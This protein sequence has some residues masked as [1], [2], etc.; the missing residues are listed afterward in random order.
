MVFGEVDDVLILG[1]D[2]NGEPRYCFFVK[3]I[4][5]EGVQPDPKKL[6]MLPKMPQMMQ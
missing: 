5:R 6:C 1:H 3:V 4:S 2:T